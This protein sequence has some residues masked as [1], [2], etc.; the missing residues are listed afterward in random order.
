MSFNLEF[1]IIFL[2]K[3]DFWFG[4]I[5]REDVTMLTKEDLANIKGLIDDQISSIKG[6]ITGMKEEIT[7]IKANMVTKKSLKIWRTG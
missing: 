5:E 1:A 4:E 3:V 2:L 7:E 6:E